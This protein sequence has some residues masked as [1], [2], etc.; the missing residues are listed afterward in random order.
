MENNSGFF[1]GNE[2]C[3]YRFLEESRGGNKCFHVQIGCSAFKG[4]RKRR[5]GGSAELAPQEKEGW[6]GGRKGEI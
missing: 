5:G 3:L 1:E 2:H 4:R 6:G